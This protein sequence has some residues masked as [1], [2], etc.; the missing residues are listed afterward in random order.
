MTPEEKFVFD[1]Q[2]YIVIKNVLTKEEIEKINK[3][4][5][6]IFPRDYSNKDS[7]MGGLRRTANV[8]KWDPACQRL[9]DHPKVTPYLKELLGPTFRLDH[10][11]CIFMSRGGQG[12]NL[13][14]GPETANGCQFYKY[15]NDTM[16]N[17]LS[18]LTFFFA[19]AGPGDGGFICVPGSHKSNFLSDMP[20]DVRELKRVEPYVVQPVAKAGDAL[21]FTEALVHGTTP[22]NADHERRTFLYKYSPGHISWSRTYYKAEDYFNPTDQQQRI[23][24]PPSVGGRQSSLD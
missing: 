1:L 10:D 17:G 20:A 15:H 19:D 14:G 3:I 4:S 13:H 22:W 18:V 11:Y 2:G 21:F 24:S 16:Q 8:S 5:D 12:G 9:I 6:R 7:N 23:L